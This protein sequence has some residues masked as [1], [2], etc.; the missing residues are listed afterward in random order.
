MASTTRT[1]SAPDA[2]KRSAT[3]SSSLRAAHRALGLHAREAAGRQPLLDLLGRGVGRQLHRQR[4]HQARVAAGS[5][6]RQQL[7]AD[8]LRRVVPHQQR[9]LL[10][11]QLRRP[12]EEQLQVVVE[13]RHR[14]DG[15]ARTA[16]RVGLVDGDGRRHA[17]DAVH[18]RP[19]HAVEELPRVGRE[20]LD[21]APLA[22]GIERVEHQARL[23]RAA[24]AGDHRHLAGADVEV[25]VLQ[26]VL[27]GAA[28]ADQAAHG[29]LS[30]GKGG[31]SRD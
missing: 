22:F 27:A 4:D 5:R 29:R 3:T 26:V 11:E 31:H 10:V 14:A 30:E 9:G 18:R 2:R 19:V 13:L 17:I 24:R 1:F 23:A 6:A 7:G 8:R 21:I 25:E 16:H 15:R 28:D 12:R 20:G